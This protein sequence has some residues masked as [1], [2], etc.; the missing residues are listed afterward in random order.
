MARYESSGSFDFTSL[1]CREVSLR[2]TG[3]PTLPASRCSPSAWANLWSRL[4]R[5]DS[6]ALL[7]PQ[8]R[9]NGAL[10]GPDCSVVAAL[11]AV[12]WADPCLARGYFLAT[13][14]ALAHTEKILTQTILSSRSRRSSQSSLEKMWGPT[15][16]RRGSILKTE[17]GVHGLPVR[18]RRPRLFSSAATRVME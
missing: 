11:R 6:P 10:G 9:K 8:T 4:R 16:I 5:L 12:V 13:K 1:L 17:T 7:S 2:M 14:Q 15:S 18:V 3:F